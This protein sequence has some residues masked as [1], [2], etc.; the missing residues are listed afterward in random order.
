MRKAEL[1]IVDRSRVWF[2][3]SILLVL[4]SLGAL[5]ANKVTMGRAL[6]Y[7]IDFTG[8]VIMDLK[9]TG[10]SENG[11][12]TGDI[13]RV[14]GERGLGKAIIRSVGDGP[15]EFLIT[16][17]SIT[18]EDLQEILDHLRTSLGDFEQ[19]SM[20]KVTPVIGKELRNAALLAVGLAIAG[21][22]VYI[23]L[24]FEWR[25]GLAAVAA[26]I[27]DVLIT[28]GFFALLRLPVDTS[29][30]AAILAVFAY[31]VN[32]TIV[33]FDRIR[34]NLRRREREPLGELV[35]R[36]VNQTLTRSVNTTLT[37]LVAIGAI[38][39]FG[40]HTTKDLALALMVGIGIG[41]YSSIFFASPLYVAIVGR[42]N[43]R[44]RSA[45]RTA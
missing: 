28:V 6:N 8:G 29:F 19:M 44:Q 45:A 23:T 22:L 5:L 25:F 1:R 21:M 37:T 40:G 11:V 12:G 32:D 2:I 9:F 42:L 30:V 34:E 13:R 20:D 14:L 36:S 16:L 39:V 43:R 38:Y 4:L 35:N 15:D 10:E 41:A 31:S 7:G 26:L 27:H 18:E 33:I 17:P 24:R 3:I